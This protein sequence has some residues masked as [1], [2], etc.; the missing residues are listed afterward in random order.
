VV[1]LVLGAGLAVAML[2]VGSWV[3]RRE[4]QTADER[5]VATPAQPVDRPKAAAEPIATAPV[6]MPIPVRIVRVAIWPPGAQ[7]EVDG[8]PADTN[9]GN[10]DFEGALG[11]VHRVRVSLLVRE[12]SQDGAVTETG[13]VPGGV[14]LEPPEAEALRVQRKQAPRAAPVEPSGPSAVSMPIAPAPS[15][16]P[17]SHPSK[18]STL[19]KTFE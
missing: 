18:F 17:S 3:A 5:P 2:V 11:S 9:S 10:V 16:A 19:N 12:T 13:P 4:S 6:P 15:S 1:A 8:R 14:R 7:V